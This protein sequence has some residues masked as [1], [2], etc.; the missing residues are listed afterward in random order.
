MIKYLFNAINIAND[1]VMQVGVYNK[2]Q[3]TL[4]CNLINNTPSNL[5]M[6]EII[7]GTETIPRKKSDMLS[8]TNNKFA[9]VVLFSE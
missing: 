4:Q 6:T 7:V 3:Y 9:L 2:Y 8:A 5:K 1:H